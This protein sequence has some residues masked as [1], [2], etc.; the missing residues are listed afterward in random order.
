MTGGGPE[1][2][3]EK[4]GANLICAK[5]ILDANRITPSF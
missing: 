2:V 3:V 1:G 5:S 4:I